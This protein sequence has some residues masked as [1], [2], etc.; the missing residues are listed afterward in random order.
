MIEKSADYQAIGEEIKGKLF[1]E[2]ESISVVF[3]ESDQQ[4]RKGGKIIFADCAKVNT[5]YEW[6]CGY[7]YMIT[8]YEPNIAYMSRKQLE[9]LLEHELLHINPNGKGTLPHDAEEFVQI[10]QKYGI[11]WSVPEEGSI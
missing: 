7:D 3:L 6:C 11:D 5:R 2:L 4:K 9:I 8:V 1:P 10:I